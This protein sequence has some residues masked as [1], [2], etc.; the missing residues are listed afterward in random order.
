MSYFSKIAQP[1]LDKE[2]VCSVAVWEAKRRAEGNFA[3]LVQNGPTE[4]M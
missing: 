3:K 2:Q 1:F 4:G